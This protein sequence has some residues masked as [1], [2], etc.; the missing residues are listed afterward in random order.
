MSSKTWKDQV[1]QFRNRRVRT[2][3]VTDK[4]EDLPLYTQLNAELTRVKKLAVKALLANYPQYKQYFKLRVGA[5]SA[6]ERGDVDSY[7]RI[8]KYEKEEFKWNKWTEFL[9]YANPPKK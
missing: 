5:K 3:G 6:L 1:Q 4:K 8:R 9:E 2:R 7:E